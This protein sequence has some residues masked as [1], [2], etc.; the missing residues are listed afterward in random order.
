MLGFAPIGAVPIGDAPQI[1]S[2]A[3]SFNGAT[4]AFELKTSGGFTGLVGGYLI[5]RPNWL[6]F[7]DFLGAAAAANITFWAEIQIGTDPTGVM[8]NLRTLAGK[9]LSAAVA[10]IQWGA[11]QKYVP[12]Q[13]QGRFINWRIVIEAPNPTI[14]G[15]ID[16][17]KAQCSVQDRVDHYLNQNVPAAGLAIVFT[18]DGD[19]DAAPFNSGPNNNNTPLVQV[20]QL[21]QGDTPVVSNLTLSGCTVEIFNGGVAVSRSNVNIIAQGF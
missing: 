13:Y 12:G 18:P 9:A 19:E 11:W 4:G 14:Q 15:I 20:S 7:S 1:G 21:Q 3:W 10:A 16:G 5:S 8:P 2:V 6:S 17:F